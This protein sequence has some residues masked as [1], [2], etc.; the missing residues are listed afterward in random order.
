LI[1]LAT[2]AMLASATPALAFD[3]SVPD[4]QVIFAED[5]TLPAGEVLD[6]DLVVF[7]GSVTLEA[8]SEV[9]G[10]VVAWGGDVEVAG[11]VD[12]DLVVF[13]GDV[14]LAGTAVVEGSLAAVGGEVRE[15]EG[16]QV[17]Q[18]EV[19]GLAGRSWRWTGPIAV[20]A[21]PRIWGVP[22]WPLAVLLA[23][24]RLVLMAMLTALVAVLWPRPAERTGETSIRSLLP[25]LGVGVLTVVIAI[26]AILGLLVTICLSPAALLVAFAVVM[27][28]VFGWAALGIQVGKRVLGALTDRRVNPFWS[29][30]LG[31][32]LLTLLSSLLNLILCVGW[33][34]SFL[35]ACVGLGAVVLTRFGTEEYPAAPAARE[36]E[37]ST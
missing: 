7:A 12:G 1:C 6:G 21:V 4:G 2:L 27:A 20:R 22:Y 16:A 37:A 35:V 15:E 5:F 23:V 32:A 3:G 17:G 8:E 25:S 19:I 11:R 9:R 29:A 30:A 33:M 36:L 26:V 34:V 31:G 13:G 24:G 10:D 28:A 14:H 18:R